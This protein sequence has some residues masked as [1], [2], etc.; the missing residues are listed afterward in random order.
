MSAADR[1]R[2][3]TYVNGTDRARACPPA[4]RRLPVAT[5]AVRAEMAR[6]GV[7]QDMIAARLGI[8]RQNVSTRLAGVVGWTP[9]EL[10]AVADL[11]TVPVIQLLHHRQPAEGRSSGYP[12]MEI[13][14]ATVVTRTNDRLHAL[15]R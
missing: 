8:R 11:L 15:H 9:E 5:E 1:K 10:A 2:V 14:T 6:T 13:G 4:Q 3:R 12:A 7:T